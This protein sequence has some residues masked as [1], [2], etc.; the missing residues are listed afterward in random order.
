MARLLKWALAVY[1]AVMLVCIAGYVRYDSYGMD[2]DAVS[3]LDMSRY[4]Q[5]GKPELAVNGYWNPA[6]SV[7]L[8]IGD[9]IARPARY[10]EL[11]VNYTVNAAI[12]VLALLAVSLFVRS[13]IGVR[14]SWGGR[15]Y[16]LPQTGLTLLGSAMVFSFWLQEMSVARVRSD[17]LLLVFLIAAAGF[18]VRLLA[19][20]RWV[21]VLPLGLMMAGAYYT[22][23]FGF[24][25]SAMLLGL[26]GTAALLPWGKNG[27]D[28]P[29]TAGRAKLLLPLGVAGLIFLAAIA[30]Y[31]AGIS[32]QRNRFTFGDSSRLLYASM[33]NGAGSIH[34]AY[35]H[36][37]GRATNQLKHPERR[38]LREPDIYSYD[39]HLN[40]TVPIWFDPAWWH[41]KTTPHIVVRG[42]ASMILHDVKMSVRFLL[43]HSAP[44]ALLLLMGVLGYRLRLDR[45]VMLFLVPM[46]WGVGMWFIYL[47]MQIQDRYIDAA[48]LVLLLPVFAL[49]EAREELER[50]K[51]AG[52]QLAATALVWMFAASFVASALSVLTVEHGLI[53]LQQFPG[54]WYD[55]NMQDTARGLAALGVNPGDRVA[56]LGEAVCHYDPYWAYLTGVQLVA[57]LPD[58]AMPA[59]GGEQDSVMLAALRSVRAKAIVAKYATSADAP[60]GWQRLGRSTYFARMVP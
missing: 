59:V 46:L 31:I 17:G 44:L 27:V 10:N 13:L 5:Q 33:I 57:E 53:A 50:E 47:V 3:F 32:R 29:G 19:T 20:R 43:L 25:A 55:V 14:E 35:S 12:F 36:E 11:E 49:L 40:G 37:M 16:A 24:V 26:L 2:G 4:L 23:S 42:Q 45:R 9:W 39:Q 21:Y 34:E 7:A 8:A 56:C 28:E 51:S 58:Q 38:I 18:G 6:Y 52:M 54:G 48:Y 60:Q 41:D 22:K 30:P 1:I 15:R